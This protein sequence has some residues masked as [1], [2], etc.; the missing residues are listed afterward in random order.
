MANLISKL[1]EYGVKSIT[2]IPKSVGTSAWQGLKKAGNLYSA[3]KGV[4]ASVKAAAGSVKGSMAGTVSDITGSAGMFESAF[5]NTTAGK[6]MNRAN[7]IGGWTGTKL[8]K[9]TTSRFGR[10]TGKAWDKVPA[11]KI[12]MGTAIVGGL[13]VGLVRGAAGGVIQRADQRTQM[14]AGMSPNNLGTDGLT[15][16]LSKR[17]HR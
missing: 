17:R 14:S 10:L 9:L 12:A 5:L 11:G 4:S 1:F 7:K 2:A 13:G 8:N 6:I 3:T 15:L 16:A